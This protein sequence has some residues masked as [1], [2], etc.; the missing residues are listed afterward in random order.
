MRNITFSAEA[1]MIEDARKVARS[2]KTTLNQLFRDWLAE[3]AGWKEQ[4]ERL[5]ALMCR[6]E[7]V[8]ANGP[9]G[10]DQMNGC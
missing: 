10:R 7:Y 3:V 2:Q 6:L 4:A 5:S 9:Y 1:S 8:R